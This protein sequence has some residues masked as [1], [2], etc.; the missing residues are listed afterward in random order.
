V[1]LWCLGLSYQKVAAT[2]W[3]LG[4]PL[5]KASAYNYV[6]RAGR[7]AL[8]LHRKSRNGSFRLVGMDTTVYKVRGHK[9][10]AAYVTDALSGQTLWIEFLDSEDAQ[11]LA[12]CLHRAVGN[13]VQLLVTDEA[14]AYKQ[15]ADKVGAEHQL[16]Q[17]H[18]K[19]AFHNRTKRLLGDASGG[20]PAA[21][22]TLRK[23]LKHLRRF[24]RAGKPLTVRL[25]SAAR[26]LLP[27]Y[28]AAR[29]PRP[30]QRACPHYRM[31]LLL[32]ELTEYGYDLFSYRR[33]KD[34]KGNYLLDG[35]NNVTERAIGLDGKI[36]YRAMR[37][38]NSK[39]SLRTVLYLQS[40]I[41]SQ[42]IRTDSPVDLSI[43]I[44]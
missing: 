36:R 33:Y 26:R 18:F 39:T 25:I 9:T 44:N 24:V 22:R 3:A 8:K 30:S 31:R 43:L 38:A 37:G 5:V 1:L 32:N 35:T 41:R 21:D 7:A 19:K 12:E 27:R 13:D 16:C 29:P 11:A 42:R 20:H 4:V 15:V 28:L 40:F 10:I 34:P 6:R 14:E 17:T 2:L 23:D